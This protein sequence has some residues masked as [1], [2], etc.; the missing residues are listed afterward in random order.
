MFAVAGGILLALFTLVALP[1]LFAA[2]FG[3]LCLLAM[4]FRS[5]RSVRREDEEFERQRAIFR[6][7]YGSQPSE[8]TERSLK[9]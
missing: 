6:Q 8:D 5:E 9:R 3:L 4:V 2:A 7:R 1:Y